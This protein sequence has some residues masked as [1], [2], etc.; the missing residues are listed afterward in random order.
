MIK[1]LPRNNKEYACFCNACCDRKS[2][3]EIK[4]QS[5]YG[6]GGTVIALCADCAKQLKAV[7]DAVE[8]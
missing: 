2:A 7:L 3:V 5:Q 1:I 4:F 6:G 8:L